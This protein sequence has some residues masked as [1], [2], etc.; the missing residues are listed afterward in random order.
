MEGNGGGR[1]RWGTKWLG[2]HDM[3][4]AGLL[5]WPPLAKDMPVAL[6]GRLDRSK[7]Q[8]L[9]GRAATIRG[10]VLREGEVVVDE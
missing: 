1:A 5:G 4:C 8:L 9:R 6:G 3:E 2:H 10:W 7:T